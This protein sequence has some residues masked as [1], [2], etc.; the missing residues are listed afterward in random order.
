MLKTLDNALDILKYFSK[1]NPWWGVREL[2][3][4]IGM[5]HAVVYRILATFEQHGF[6]VQDSLTQKYGLGFKIL[7]YSSI[8]RS[9]LKITSVIYPLMKQM[10]E[11]SGESVALT[12]RDGLCGVIL[13]RV[14]TSNP[15]K[16][17]HS[18]GDRAPLYAGATNKVIM[19]YLSPE[20]QAKIMKECFESGNKKNISQEKLTEDLEKIRKNGWFFSQGEVT[21]DTFGL[22]APLFDDKNEII[23]SISVSG[24]EY[25]MPQENIEKTLAILLDGRD[26]IQ[27]FLLRYQTDFHRR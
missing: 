13:E 10:A 19:A 3:R 21:A 16:F 6:L 18:V 4:E 26:K 20:E 9:N 24:P 5:S 14:E 12:L 27:E 7:E 25:R 23:A 8:I 15:I 22:A 11:K 17:V 1:E 2:A